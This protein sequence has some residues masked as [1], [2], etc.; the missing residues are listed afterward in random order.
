MH[1]LMAQIMRGKARVNVD[2][3]ELSISTSLCV[4]L[5]D[6]LQT[7]TDPF[8]FKPPPDDSLTHLAFFQLLEEFSKN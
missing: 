3:R 5:S 4:H 7:K 1:H 6:V 8:I 2:Y